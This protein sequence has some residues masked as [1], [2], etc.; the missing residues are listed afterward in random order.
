MKKSLES[1]TLLLVSA[2][3]YFLAVGFDAKTNIIG[4]AFALIGLITLVLGII[5]FIREKKQEKL[6]FRKKVQ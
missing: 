4:S 1:R 2:L 3:S 6:E 5:R